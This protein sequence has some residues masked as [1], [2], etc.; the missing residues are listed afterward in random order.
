[1]LT[2]Q[3][4]AYQHPNKE[5]LFD[6]IYLT[7]NKSDKI[8]LV[9]NNGAGKS[10][11]LKIIAGMLVPVSGQVHCNEP[12]YY[13][14][15]HFGQYDNLT[16]A[17]ALQIDR[18]LSALHCILEGDV[19]EANMNE[20]D[21]DWSIEERATAALACWQLTKHSLNDPLK[22]LSGGEKTKVF[23]AGIAIHQPGMVLMDEPGNH[24]DVNSRQ[25]LYNYIRHAKETMLIVS[26]DRTL[27]NILPI[28]CE[29][30]SNSIKTYGGNYDFY[31]KQKTT[32][33]D[34]LQQKI[35]SREKDLRKAKAT[36]REAIERKQ[37]QDARGRKKQDQAGVPTIMLNTLR[38]NAEKST[39]KLQ[40]THSEKITAISEELSQSRKE[41]EAIAQMKLDLDNSCLHK[42]K[43]LI[44]AKAIN[45]QYLQHLLWQ[46]PQSFQVLSGERIAIKGNNGSGKTT[47]VKMML[48]QKN[49]D[50]GTIQ[51]AGFTSVYIDQDYSL[52][53][54]D[55]TIY[56]QAASFNKTGLQE[57]EI[58]IRLTRFLFSKT[59]W[60]NACATLSGGEKMRLLLC[61]LTIQNQAPDVLVLD[62]PTN[63]LDIQNVDILLNAVNDYQGTVIV[64]SHDIDF[65]DALQV[66]KIIELN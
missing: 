5:L 28:T 42:G 35:Q 57:H 31:K 3:N 37:K 34:A 26:H 6:G 12:V 63:N 60:N 13:V 30:T 43:I 14:P 53:D 55:T 29:L 50:H 62:E 9:G 7:V 58:K 17:Q 20:L 64:I 38:N 54:P 19:S 51:R 56:E 2:L 11:L 59:Q 33:A 46:Q 36:E 32:E 27:L 21:D 61:C 15:Q 1:M 65:L 16:I 25:L 47:L 23:L 52:I 66:A 39:S 24:L 44:N 8:A 40:S 45:V 22:M 4:I 41:L 10:T 48:G 18:K 49:P